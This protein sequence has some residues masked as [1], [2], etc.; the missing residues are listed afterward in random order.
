MCYGNCGL[1]EYFVRELFMSKAG[2]GKRKQAKARKARP[3]TRQQRQRHRLSRWLRGLNIVRRSVWVTW[4]VVFAIAALLASFA[5]IY[6]STWRISVSPGET[7]KEF[8]PFA[9]MFILNNEGQFAINDVKFLCILNH[10]SYPND[11]RIDQSAGDDA[12]FNV[13]VLEANAKTSTPCY[14]PVSFGPPS[15]VDV[16]ITVSYR[17]SF[18]PFRKVGYFRFVAQRK[19]NGSYLWVPMTH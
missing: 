9:T 10:V 15:V 3:L 17:P 2:R 7:L 19:D 8:D 14:L 6:F 4:V 18:Y 12:E 11:L 13:P 5:Q 1:N 16:T